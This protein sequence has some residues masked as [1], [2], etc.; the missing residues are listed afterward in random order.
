MG[1]SICLIG[2]GSRSHKSRSEW[3]D[4]YEKFRQYT[5]IKHDI[6]DG[7]IELQKPDYQARLKN[8]ATRYSRVIAVP[9]SLFR[10][11]HVKNDFL[12]A[13]Q[14][15]DP[16]LQKKIRFTRELGVTPEMVDALL[17][18]FPQKDTENSVVIVVGR[19]SSDADANSD[20]H[21]L[22]RLAGENAGCDNIYPTYSRPEK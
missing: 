9:V 2:H 11:N 15:F 6:F 19:G 8:L 21:K 18:H 1:T 3:Q 12:V 4:F 7:F 10:A 17:S 16:G 14:S 5:A 13:L 22:C 20:F